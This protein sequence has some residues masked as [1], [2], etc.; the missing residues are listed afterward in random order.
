MSINTVSYFSET[1]QKMTNTTVILPDAYNSSTFKFPVLWLLHGLGGD[2]S[3]WIRRTKIEEY[4]NKY[5][6]A[7]IMPDVQRSFYTDMSFGGDYWTYLT[8]ELYKRMY[9]T[10]PLSSLRHHNFV[11]GASMGGYGAL[12]WAL[13]DPEK[14]SAVA[15]MSPVLDL[16]DFKNRHLLSEKEFSGIFINQDLSKSPLSIKWLLSQ[17]NLNF[18]NSLSV[19]TSSGTKDFLLEQNKAFI[20]LF[21]EKFQE[22]YSWYIGVGAHDWDLWRPQLQKIMEWL[23]MK[24]INH[25]S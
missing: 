23:P 9:S 3:I 25:E 10:F 2:N 4:A 14:F 21:Q 20:P 16:E 15:A 8:Q 11:C 7:V 12:K 13:T 5:G 22:N 1:L 24:E 18:G 19:F 17:Y 6:L